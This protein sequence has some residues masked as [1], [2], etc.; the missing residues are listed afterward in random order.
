[1]EFENLLL[2]QRG[3]VAILTIARPPVNALNSALLA[4]IFGSI[5]VISR[6]EGVRALVVTG[7]G[8]A[9]VAGADI[10]EMERITTAEA[11]QFA[12]RGQAVLSGFEA[13]EMPVIAAVNGFALGGGCELAMACD[14]MLAGRKALFGQPE[15]KL[16]VIPGFGGTQRLPKLVG[17]HRARELCFTGRTVRADEA[18]EI[19][20]ALKVCDDV[21][22]S[23]IEMGNSIAK[24]GPYAVTL[25]KRAMYES[26]GAAP[27]AGF[28][29][30][31]NLFAMCFGSEDQSEGMAAFLSK[32]EA[33]FTGR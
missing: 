30:E 18:V 3:H 9:F 29:L 8:K 27:G 22:A 5:G 14:I 25:T 23:A 19:G 33:Q 15:V 21:V 13:L 16:G 12:A 10:A 6:M 2:E 11:S 20:L 1:M 31:R 28:A 4:E 32:R 17:I 26:E 7:Q 24:N